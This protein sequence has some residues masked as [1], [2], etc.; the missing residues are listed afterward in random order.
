MTE[1]ERAA[2]LK[3]SPGVVEAVARAIAQADDEDYMEDF[4]RYDKRARAALAEIELIEAQAGS[5]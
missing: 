1:R 4:A 3:T 5:P 2:P